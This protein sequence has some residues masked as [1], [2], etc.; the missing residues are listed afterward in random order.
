[1]LES[2]DAVLQ[3]PEGLRKQAEVLLNLGILHRAGAEDAFQ[4]S[5]A[6][7]KK[8]LAGAAGTS[9]DRYNLALAHNNLTD[10]LIDQKRLPEAGPHFVEAV[11]EFERLVTDTPNSMDFQHVF[12]IVL[13]G[14][15]KW[16][17]I[18]DK[19]ADAKAALTSAIEHQRQAVRLSRNAPGCTL[20]L[21][22]HLIDLA[23]INCILGSYDDAGK[24]ALEVPKTVPLTS[25]A[26][27]CY[28][29]ARVLARLVKQASTDDRLTHPERDRLSRVYL[30]R[31]VVLLRE[32]IDSN[33]KL[34]EQ[35]KAEQDFKAL[36]KH[37]QFQA[38]MNT[39]VDILP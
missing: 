1:L 23:D 28:D 11:A 7:S 14:Q 17:G 30:T 18:T 32:A 31:T 13:A 38:I 15:A 25:R 26:Q 34:A 8:L 6:V 5:I 16:F 20:A 10:Y 33:T 2:V 22:E 4:R 9:E 24:L 29:A 27:G 39:F 3:T 21:A 19:P 37:P 35:I 12:G 36:E